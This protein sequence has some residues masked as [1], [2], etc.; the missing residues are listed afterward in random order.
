MCIRD[1]LT[2]ITALEEEGHLVLLYH[3]WLYGGLTLHVSL[4]DNEAHISSITN[5]I[6]GAAFY[7]REIQELFGVKFEGLTH[8]ELLFLADTWQGAPPMQPKPATLEEI[9]Q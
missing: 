3:F 2:A 6:P 1:S 8:Q 4:S 5:L 9:D 7:E